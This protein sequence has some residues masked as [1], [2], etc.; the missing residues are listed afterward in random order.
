[1]AKHI[2]P[3]TFE[4][5]FRD[6][7]WGGRNLEAFG[8]K[9]PPGIVAESWEISG[10][11]SSP[12]AVDAGPY[13]GRLLTELLPELGIDL[14]GR[15]NQAALERGKFPLLV[16]LLD[17]NQ[18]LSVQVHP[19]DEY[20]RVHENGELGKTEMWY[21]L[22]AKP[23][24]RLIYGLR[25]GVTREDFLRALQEGDLERCLHYLPVRE[26]DVVF[27]PTGTVHA[28]LAG[29]VV[30]EIQQNSDAT[31]RVYDWNR[32]GPDGKP[33]PL[34]IEKAMDV[35][36]FNRVEPGAVRPEP[37]EVRDGFRREVITRCPYFIVE[38]IELTAGERFSGACTGDTFE[39]WGCVRGEAAVTWAGDPVIL[40]TVRFTLLPAALGEFAVEAREPAVLL[41]TYVE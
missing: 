11:F 25:R 18:D 30:V 2:Y 23:G 21:I 40:P 22:R 3:L 8:R 31:Y 9:L 10:H 36:D 20:A 38:K 32:V 7:I 17:A 16:K 41:R 28:L 35:I 33:R 14:V 12:T 37:V 5:Q 15:R 19:D 24:A 26:G 34:H 29:L 13:K 6:Y 27:I 39:I 4:P 1:M